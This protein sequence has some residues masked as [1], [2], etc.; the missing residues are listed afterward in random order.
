MPIVATSLGVAETV[1]KKQLH[2]LR[3]RYRWLLRDEVAHT[4][5]H[6]AEVDDEI[7]LS[8]C[9]A[10]RGRRVIPLQARL[11]SSVRRQ[12][13]DPNLCPTAERDDPDRRGRLRKLS[14]PRGTRD[15]GRSLCAAFEACSKKRT[16]PTH[17]GVS[18]NYEILEEIG[19]GGMGVIYRAR[20]RH[21]QRIVALKRV[22][23]YQADSHE[24]LVRFRREAEAAASLD[25]PNILPI[26][27]VS[28]SEERPPV[29]QHEIRDRRKSANRGA[30]RCAL[31]LTSACVSSPRSR[32]RSPTPI[33][34][35][36]LHRDL[37]AREIFSSM[38]T[39][40]RS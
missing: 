4:V 19:R 2:N 22:L 37:A 23:A 18:G 15:G 3:Q 24:T 39:A 32:V 16:C 28:E 34:H 1:V 13:D 30:E 40:N 25:H 21:S 14:P 29:F 12:V 38:P 31:S 26:Y 8:L 9:S 6:P 20:Q 27:E 17:T 33:E 35:G 36:I 10:R 5:D 7:R 11:I